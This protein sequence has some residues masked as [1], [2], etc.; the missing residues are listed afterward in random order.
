MFFAEKSD[1]VTLTTYRELVK[2]LL[3]KGDDTHKNLIDKI[4]VTVADLAKN[5]GQNLSKVDSSIYYVVE[6]L[7][8][9]NKSYFQSTIKTIV[10]I[11][12]KVYEDLEKILGSLSSAEVNDLNL[13][14]SFEI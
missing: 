8:S 3:D 11:N 14:D 2:N 5:D 12:K 1:N 4:I 6:K 9:T 10:D 7:Y 13:N